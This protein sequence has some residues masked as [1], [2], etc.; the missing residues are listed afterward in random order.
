MDQPRDTS[1]A[2]LILAAMQSSFKA[3]RDRAMAQLSIFIKS[4]VG[5]ADHATIVEDCN[6]L[7]QEIAEAEDCLKVINTV[8]VP[9][10]ASESQE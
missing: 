4:H 7:V 9:V 3:Q 10:N 5:V 8:F 6:K 1:S 2:E